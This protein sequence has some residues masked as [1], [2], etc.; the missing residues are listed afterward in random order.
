MLS[1]YISPWKK[2]NVVMGRGMLAPW[3]AEQMVSVCIRPVDGSESRSE[4]IGLDAEKG[5]YMKLLFG[6]FMMNSR[7]RRQDISW[8]KVFFLG[9]PRANCKNLKIAL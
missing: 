7:G 6:D 2:G 1:C 4:P 5:R 8:Q 9:Y 3:S